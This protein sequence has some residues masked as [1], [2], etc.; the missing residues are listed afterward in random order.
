MDRNVGLTE[1]YLDVLEKDMKSICDYI[2][3]KLGVEKVQAIYLTGSHARSEAS[4]LV[5]PRY[6][7]ISDYDILIIGSEIPLEYNTILGQEC[8]KFFDYD[9]RIFAVDISIYHDVEEI[10]RNL[11]GYDVFGCNICLYGEDILN[12]K[13]HMCCTVL[14]N[15]TAIYQIHNRFKNLLYAFSYPDIMS[16]KNNLITEYIKHR[17]YQLV[18]ALMKAYCIASKQYAS[19]FIKAREICLTLKGIRP[20]WIQSVDM[21]VDRLLYVG[22]SEES[23]LDVWNSISKSVFEMYFNY[24]NVYFETAEFYDLIE[25]D[26][27]RKIKDSI[28]IYMLRAINGEKHIDQEQLYQIEQQLGITTSVYKSCW[29]RWEMIRQQWML[30]SLK[31]TKKFF[32]SGFIWGDYG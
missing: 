5:E 8:T 30:F 24:I 17:I 18:I 16:Y 12:N 27:Y 15:E 14:T 13:E 22:F 19:S 25:G 3:E 23:P 26:E 28:A 1:L 29:K 9:C 2:R 4:Y 11:Y 7:L 10:P 6:Q 21:S 31:E 32:K 20:E